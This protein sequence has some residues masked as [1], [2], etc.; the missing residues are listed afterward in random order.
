MHLSWI[1]LER[2][3]VASSSWEYVAL[4]RLRD[5]PSV[6]SGFSIN[7]H[8]KVASWQRILLGVRRWISTTVRGGNVRMTVP[9][10]KGELQSDRD[11]S[12]PA[13]RW[14]RIVELFVNE[15]KHNCG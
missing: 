6:R 7:R 12:S 4:G 11:D 1:K 5:E 9:I 3:G 13:M 8:N 14:L 2:R 15:R 10:S